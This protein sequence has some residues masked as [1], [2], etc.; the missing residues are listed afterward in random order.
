MG[1]N[2]SRITD[3]SFCAADDHGNDCCSHAVEGPAREG[4]NN[5]FING[6]GALR[7][8]D[9]GIH[10]TCC[11]P[12]TW[13]TDQCSASVF[14]NGRGAVRKTDATLHCGGPGQMQTGSDNVFIGG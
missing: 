7:K 13:K 9:R 11:G 10:S 12:N 8:N 14:I 3:T 2:A 1:K 6:L 5:V 4:S